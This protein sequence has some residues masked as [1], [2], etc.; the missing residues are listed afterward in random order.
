M[1]EATASAAARP[2]GGDDLRKVRRDFF[3]FGMLFTDKLT[4][5][6]RELHREGS[7]IYGEC[8]FIKPETWGY[9]GTSSQ[10]GSRATVVKG[11]VPTARRASAR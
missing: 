8:P 6:Q 10:P 2:A 7:Q 1:E 3:E 4:E 5:L 9:E 11:R